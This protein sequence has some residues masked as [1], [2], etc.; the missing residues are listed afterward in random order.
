VPCSGSRWSLCSM[1]PHDELEALPSTV[2]CSMCQLEAAPLVFSSVARCLTCRDTVCVAHLKAHNSVHKGH[3]HKVFFLSNQNL[4]QFAQSA[5]DCDSP[6]NVSCSTIRSSVVSSDVLSSGA[7]SSSVRPPAASAHPKDTI[8]T[9]FPSSPAPLQWRQ[10]VGY[11]GSSAEI[12]SA[13]MP[14]AASYGNRLPWVDLSWN[15]PSLAAADESQISP[16]FVGERSV[17]GGDGFSGGLW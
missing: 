16:L 8:E 11:F 2:P 17:R 1:Q 14:W 12:A 9:S 6:S 4:A 15:A 7:A 3:G 10:P 5:A 13:D